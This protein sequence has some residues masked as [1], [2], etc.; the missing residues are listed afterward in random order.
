MVIQDNLYIYLAKP[1]ETPGLN[2]AILR[3]TL[4]WAGHLY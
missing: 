1:F 3:Q 4:N 2:L